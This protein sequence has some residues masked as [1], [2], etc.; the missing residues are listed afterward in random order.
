MAPT[1]TGP[2]LFSFILTNT[3][4]PV[5]FIGTYKLIINK[6][7]LR[8]QYARSCSTNGGNESENSQLQLTDVLHEEDG[9]CE[10]A[11]TEEDAICHDLHGEEICQQQRD[12]AEPVVQSQHVLLLHSG[13]FRTLDLHAGF[14]GTYSSTQPPYTVNSG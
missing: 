5:C 11:H 7:N 14:T 4:R 2:G 6:T 3:T 12:L 9:H 10:F 8:F 1:W 13:H